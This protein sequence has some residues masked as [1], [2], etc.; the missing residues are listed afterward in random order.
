M[1]NVYAAPQSDVVEVAQGGVSG[2]ERFS[3]WYVFLLAIV[4]LGVYLPYWL[5]SRTKVLNAQSEDQISSGFVWTTILLYALALCTS[6][7]SAAV[8]Q[9]LAELVLLD[10][11]VSLVANVFMIVW[12]FKFR[13][14]LQKLIAPLQLKTNPILTFLFQT[15][16]MQYKVNE[17]IDKQVS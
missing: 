8:G 5:Y 10:S 11:G 16:Y 7:A 4:T 1:E 14:R 17:A 9:E 15:L 12:A 13:N 2:F 3:T 6:I